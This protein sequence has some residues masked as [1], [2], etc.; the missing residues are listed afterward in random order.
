[1]QATA[2]QIPLSDYSDIEGMLQK[3]YA[4]KLERIVID[5]N[6]KEK[7]E[8]PLRDNTP[9]NT[10]PEFV[11]FSPDSAKTYISLQENNGVLIVDTATAKIVKVF[12]LGI[13]EHDTDTQYDSKVKFSNKLR[14]LREPDGIAISPDGKY[15]LTADEGDTDPKVS[16]ILGGKPAGGGRTLSVFDAK[17]GTFISDTACQLD[18]M[19]HSVGL[20]PDNRSEKKGSEPENVISFEIEGILYAAVALERANAIAL[21]Y[22][23]NPKQPKVISIQAVDPNA[24]SGAKFAPEGLA[25]YEK[26]GRHYVF[27]ANEKSGTMTVMEVNTGGKHVSA[28]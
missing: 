24:S 26:D 2:T 12:G 4:R 23:A 16:K 8:V 5:S 6:S 27:S 25:H 20:Y 15:L 13:T 7:T 28:N 21:V 19:A 11:T 14:A 3:K 9:M 22:L 17:T 1:M 18:E 10:E